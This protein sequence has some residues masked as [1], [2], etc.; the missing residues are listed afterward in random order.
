VIVRVPPSER[1]RE[2]RGVAQG[3]F[4][5][6][7][8]RISSSPPK[9]PTCVVRFQPKTLTDI[10]LHSISQTGR[11]IPSCEVNLNEV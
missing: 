2:R 8:T 6:F 3:V 10:N 7:D 1:A 4:L 5:H 11:I 9:V